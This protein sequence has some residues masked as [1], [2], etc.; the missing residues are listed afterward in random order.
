[1]V[2]DG[3]LHSTT[4]TIQ[5]LAAATQWACGGNTI[6]VV[7]DAKSASSISSVVQG[8]NMQQIFESDHGGKQDNNSIS[9]N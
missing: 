2:V 6:R 1:M 8:K 4:A 5:P 7:E 3:G 9:V